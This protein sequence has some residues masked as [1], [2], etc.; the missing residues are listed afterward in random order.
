LEICQGGELFDFIAH[1]GAF[2]EPVARH[3][4]KQFMEGLKYCHDQGITH[5]DLKPENLLLNGEFDLKI[6]DFG[7]ASLIERTD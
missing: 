5:R 2:S 1:G 4:F 7:F 6:A 3:F